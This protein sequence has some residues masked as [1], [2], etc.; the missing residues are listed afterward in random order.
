MIFLNALFF[1]PAAPLSSEQ[2]HEH[3]QNEWTIDNNRIILTWLIFIT[4]WFFFPTSGFKGK[5]II[6]NHRN[7]LIRRVHFPYY[8]ILFP[9]KFLKLKC[10][11]FFL[12]IINASEIPGE[13]GHKNANS[14]TLEHC[15][16]LMGRIFDILLNVCT[17]MKA[18]FSSR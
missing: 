12:A 15:N 8:F 13:N 9:P 4:A 16:K 3:W 6:L 17:W 5:N 7:S 10:H 2:T 18:K 14:P 1:L 11:K